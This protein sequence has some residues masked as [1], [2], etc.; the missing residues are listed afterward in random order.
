VIYGV[1]TG[2]LYSRKAVDE[3]R[4]DRDNWKSAY[5][6]SDKANRVLMSQNSDLIDSAKTTDRIIRSLPEI[7]VSP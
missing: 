7:G 4:G 6:E 1:L 2:K 5:F 3:I